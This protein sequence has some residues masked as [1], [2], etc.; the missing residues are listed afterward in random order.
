MRCGHVLQ[1]PEFMAHTTPRIIQKYVSSETTLLARHAWVPASCAMRPGM[2]SR[3]TSAARTLAQ[4]RRR[5]GTWTS[6]SRQFTSS[7][8]RR[9]RSHRAQEDQHAARSAPETTATRPLLS[10]PMSMALLTKLVAMTGSRRAIS[11]SG[12]SESSPSVEVGGPRPTMSWVAE[13]AAARISIELS[14]G[15]SVAV[16]M[17]S[18]MRSPLRSR[19]LTPVVVVEKD[20]VRGTTMTASG[21]RWMAMKTLQDLTARSGD[22]K[23][24]SS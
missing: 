16:S 9:G 4:K 19:R 21:I 18:A 1:A 14:A 3:S 8:Q 23:P 20:V 11:T 7:H 2:L 15:S 24:P 10:P 22:P 13:S 6:C 12:S 17:D 5:K